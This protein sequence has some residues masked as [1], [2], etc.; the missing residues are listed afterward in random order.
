MEAVESSQKINPRRLKSF[1]RHICVIA[2]KHKERE[3]ARAELQNQL[4]RLKRFSSKKMGMDDELKELDRKISLVLEKEME[5]LGI[6][7][8]ESGVSKELM[9]RVLDNRE[10]IRSINYSI[11]E[12]RERLEDYIRM[13][14]ERERRI[15]ELEEKI[16]AKVGKKKNVS[17]L[18]NKLKKL[19]T[20]YNKLKKK[21][22]DVSRV[23]SRIN[24]LKLRLMV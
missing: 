16:R 24:S 14:T 7:Q 15:N 1:V 13:K 3:E 11:N 10:R 19:E 21:G 22:I 20:M 4:K 9:N 12:I 18:R 6:R 2:K 8:G 5:L 17:L 23:E